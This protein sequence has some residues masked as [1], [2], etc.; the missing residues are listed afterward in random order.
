[1]ILLTILV[2]VMM[3]DDDSDNSDR[4]LVKVQSR[5]NRKPHHF[6]DASVTGC[7]P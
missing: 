5:Y 6:G 3:F 1:M 4:L 7:P 2:V